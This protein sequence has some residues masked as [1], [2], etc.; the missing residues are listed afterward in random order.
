MI[1]QL[2][3]TPAPYPY[4]FILTGPSFLGDHMDE[5]IRKELGLVQIYTGN[6]KG[7]TTAALGLSLRAS[8]RGL[9]VLFLQF[10][11]PDA[12]YGEQMACSCLENIT[13]VSMGLAH[14]VGNM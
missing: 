4:R 8:G 12:G 6:G 1:L 7:K 5:D 3:E 10:L 14:F 13:V 9:K 11:K 2:G